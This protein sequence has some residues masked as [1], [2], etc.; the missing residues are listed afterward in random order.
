MMMRV[1]ELSTNECGMVCSVCKVVY[2]FQSL[3]CYSVRVDTVV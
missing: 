1:S 2:V 3:A